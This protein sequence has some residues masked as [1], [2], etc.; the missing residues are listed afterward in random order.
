MSL[1]EVQKALTL[2]AAN[3]MGAVWKLHALSC[4]NTLGSAQMSKHAPTAPRAVDWP[5]SMHARDHRKPG[6]QRWRRTTMLLPKTSFEFFELRMLTVDRRLPAEA[7]INAR[8]EPCFHSASGSAFLQL[9][10][11]DAEQVMLS[12]AF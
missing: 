9:F 12:E 8:L 2:P 3:N 5:D 4:A 10:A 11:T 7:R 1:P 6:K